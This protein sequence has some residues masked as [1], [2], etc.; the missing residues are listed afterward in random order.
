MSVIYVCFVNKFICII[1]KDSTYK[2]YQMVCVFE[3]F[4]LVCGKQY[5]DSLKNEK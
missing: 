2:W 1:L 5:G 4:H 3:V